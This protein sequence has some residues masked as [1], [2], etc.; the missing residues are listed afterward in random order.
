MEQSR[1]TTTCDVIIVGLGP[2][3]AVLANLLGQYGWS[4]VGL[5]RDEDLYY[6]PRAV[7]FDD[8]IMRVFQFAGLDQ[9]I[10]RTSEPFTDMEIKLKAGGKPVTRSKIGSQDRRYGHPGAWWFHQPTLEQHF[11]DG[12]KRFANVRALYGYRVLGVQQG[13]ESVTAFVS[14]SNGHELEVKGRYLIGCDGGRS[15]IRK[16][17][18]LTLESA[19]F[20]EAWVVV[21]TKTR[22]GGKDPGLP[23]HHSQICNPSQPVTY[24]PMAGPYY[25]WQ[26]MVM[27]NKSE[28]EATDPAYVR[29]QLAEHVDLQKVD[30]TR[31]AYYKFHGLWAPEWRNERILLAGDSAHQMPPFLGQGM[32]SGVRDAHS[33]CW[34]L[35]LV[36]AQKAAPSIFDDYVRERSAHV[37]EIIN[38]A[39]FLGN[40][41]QTRSRWVALFRNTLLFRAT[42]MFTFANRLLTEK[43]NR[44]KPLAG[45]FLGGTHSLSG[46]L[47]IQPQVC[48]RLNGSLVLLDEFLGKGFALLVRDRVSKT[49]ASCAATL[50][51]LVPLQVVSFNDNLPTDGV[52]DAQG[53]L[54]RWFDQHHIDFVLIRPDRYVFDAGKEAD[55]DRVAALFFKQ[56]NHPQTIT[57]LG[58]AA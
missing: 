43:A 31:I 41:I 45:G 44:K 6:A 54:G 40:I 11:K 17:A 7:H 37:K 23:S 21:D 51:Q 25:E 18:N 1:K 49:C 55:L 47:A 27:G 28:R 53:H 58:A 33:L 2:T 10:G 20:D 9:E 19:D 42:K 57:A 29:R 52:I 34:R 24:V 13:E 39:I 16:A 35:D 8:E 46:H 48:S 50:G 14:G 4:V 36:L 32:C 26:F 3:G 38:G 22:S 15:L 5:E 12:M 30:I 56:F